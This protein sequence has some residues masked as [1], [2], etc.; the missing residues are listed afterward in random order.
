MDD[1]Q[2]VTNPLILLSYWSQGAIPHPAPM[3]T[4]ATATF[5]KQICYR[6]WSRTVWRPAR[7]STYQKR[8]PLATSPPVTSACRTEE[9]DRF[10]ARV[11]SVS[12]SASRAVVTSRI[13]RITGHPSSI[14]GRR[15]FLRL[16]HMK[17]PAA[18][19]KQPTQN[20]GTA[21]RCSSLET[22]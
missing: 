10:A 12:L 22:H 8:H 16:C 20:R 13:F 6:G 5:V 14:A 18:F 2:S 17:E 15:P 9:D 1:T 21:G 7:C 4:Q 3:A 11:A 19:P